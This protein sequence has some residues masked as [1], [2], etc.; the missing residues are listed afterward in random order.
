MSQANRDGLSDRRLSGMIRGEKMSFS[1]RLLTNTAVWSMFS[2]MLQT[3][4]PS[5]TGANRQ[6]SG[7][8]ST[9]PLFC[10]P[11]CGKGFSSIPPTLT[12]RFGC[13]YYR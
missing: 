3:A 2:R 5:V 6:A 13:R 10:Q 12:V 8:F 4:H 7:S 11:S 9:I 1:G